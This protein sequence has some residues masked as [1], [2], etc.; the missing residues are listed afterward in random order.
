[1]QGTAQWWVPSSCYHT[2]LSHAVWVSFMPAGTCSVLGHLSTSV[3]LLG[4]V[5]VSACSPLQPSHPVI[6][7][8]VRVMICSMQAPYAAQCLMQSCDA[9]RRMPCCV[10]MWGKVRVFVLASPLSC[11]L[12]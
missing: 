3:C 9:P 8:R 5:A 12:S 4:H 2:L 11:F 6:V 10:M 7:H 1:M